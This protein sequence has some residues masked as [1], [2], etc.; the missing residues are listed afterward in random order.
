M[1]IVKIRKLILQDGSILDMGSKRSTSNITNYL[2]TNE[3]IN[4]ADKFTK[5][6]NDL[7]ID[8]EKINEPNEKI[9]KNVFLL[10]VLEHIYNFKNCFK[11]CYQAL[12]NDGYIYGATPFMFHVHGSPNDYFRY[13]EQSLRKALEDTGFK[14]IRVEIICGGIFICF[15]SSIARITERIPF[16]NNILFIICQTLDFIIN[17]FSKE[18]KKIFPLGYFFMGNK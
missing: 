8:L 12:D 3:K 16:L 10:N 9:F 6:P 5:D 1:Q 13:T 17:L 2:N 7:V 4:Y 14:N 15:Y 18:I 11:N